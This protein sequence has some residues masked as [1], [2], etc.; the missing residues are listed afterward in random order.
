MHQTAKVYVD[1]IE[2]Q[3]L[4]TE[5]GCEFI[6]LFRAVIKKK[7]FDSE[8]DV[9]V[10]EEFH[11]LS[12]NHSEENETKSCFLT[13]DCLFLLDQGFYCFE[14][15][16]LTPDCGGSVAKNTGAV[17]E[18]H[19]TVMENLNGLFLSL[20]NKFAKGAINENCLIKTGKD[21]SHGIVVSLKNGHSNRLGVPQHSSYQKPVLLRREKCTQLFI[22][23]K[24]GLYQLD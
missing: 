13:M 11:P 21:G 2:N 15:A 18:I 19:I 6:Q 20:A 3:A 9:D 16:A 5:T 23:T 14:N 4:A 17:S 22:T 1:S 10:I 7:T 24:T 12:Q 8:R